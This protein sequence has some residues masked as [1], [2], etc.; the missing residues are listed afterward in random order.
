MISRVDYASLRFWADMLY[1][2]GMFAGIVW[3]ALTARVKANKGAIDVVATLVDEHD[4]RLIKL[5]ERGANAPSHADL[6]RVYER[7]DALNGQMQAI[8]GH[9]KA[10]GNQVGMISEH[11]LRDHPS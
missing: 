6:G 9:V 2:V 1:R 4:T 5:E 7:L 10:M 3:L 8:S 11:L